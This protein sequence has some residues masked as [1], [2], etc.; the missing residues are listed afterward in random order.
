M[1][2]RR[3]ILLAAVFALM[4]LTGS[5]AFAQQ[6]AS[7]DH[8]L[9]DARMQAAV[10]N[11][12]TPARADREALRTLL[13]DPRVQEVADGYGIDLQR[14]GDAVATLRGSELHQLGERARQLNDD[15]AGG[16]NT[17]V[18]SSTTII[19]ALLILLIILVAD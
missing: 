13:R 11:A 12:A 17:I 5:R 3:G 19:I 7:Q 1:A 2:T 15:L 18:I 6:T 4:P 10:T 9:D 16:A 14:A 8:V